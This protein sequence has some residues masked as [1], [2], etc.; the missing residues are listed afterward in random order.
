MNEMHPEGLLF[1]AMV[2]HRRGLFAW[3][4]RRFFDHVEL[5]AKTEARLVSLPSQGR[6]IYVMRTRSLLDYLFF[7]HLFL[8][9]GMPLARFANG[10]NLT[11]LRGSLLVGLWGWLNRDRRPQANALDLLE[12]VI[13]RGQS[14]LIFMKKRA[15]NT[16]RLGTRD[17]V[18][19]LV[20]L[21]RE[22]D[23]PLLLVPQ[24]IAW[25][26]NPPSRRRSWV[27]I[28]FGEQEASGRLRKIG[29]FI[30]HRR[31]ATVRVGAP[32]NLKEVIAAHEGWSDARLAR[33]VRRVLFIHLGHEAMSVRG[34]AVKP[35]PMIRREIL[36]RR[37]FI[38][39]MNEQAKVLG[40]TPSAVQEEAAAY[41]KEI[42]AS[43]RFDIL[44]I[45][46]RML[47]SLFT[48]VFQGVE[49]DVSEIERVKEA[50]K[51][52]RSAPLILAPCHKSHA[53]YLLLSWILMRHGFIAPH[54][55]AGIN[56]SFFP[57][58]PW[59][60]HSGAF[61]LRRSFKGLDLYKLVFRQ[62]L[63]KL[64]REG[65]PIEF[66]LE[67][68]RS[69]TG[70][71][72]QPKMGMLSMLLEG[73][74]E[75]E[76]KDLQFIPIHISY[77]RVVE[78][79]SYRHELTG[80]AKRSESVGGVVKAS[81]VL[82][83]R[84]GRIYVTLEAP[85]RLS[86]YAYGRGIDLT[87][88][89][90]DGFRSTTRA[91]AYHLMR[92]I[93]VATIITPSAL[94]GTVLLSHKRRGITGIR[95]RE[96]VGFLL[97]F[98][99]SRGARISRSIQHTLHLHEKYIQSSDERDIIEGFQARG[100]ALRPLI[101]EALLLLKRLV[102]IEE[103]G[104]QIIYIIPERNRIELDY[105]RNGVLS[106]LVS[107]AIVAT[108]IRSSS[109]II[110]RSLLREQCQNLS[111]WLRLEFIYET[112]TSFEDVFDSVLNRMV[113]ESL[114]VVNESGQIQTYDLITLDF[115][116]GALQHMIEGY[117]IATDALRFLAY[118]PMDQKIW[119]EKA[120]EHG[121]RE[122]LSGDLQRPEASSTA[123]LKAS[124]QR[125]IDEGWIITQTQP[126]ARKPIK[127]YALSPNIQ[128]DLII[129]KRD[130]LGAFLVSHR[131]E[132]PHPTMTLSITKRA[133]QSIN[134]DKKSK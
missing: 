18:G 44:Q 31:S 131:N 130:E 81:K 54:I 58:G 3:F 111:D 35:G 67:G 71:L 98:L 30:R 87:K 116:R 37:R 124:M 108:V 46:A 32:I 126:T 118:G 65:Y 43:W 23:T 134:L 100:E 36:E 26:P 62:Y 28:A 102:H 121:E 133:F 122:F 6:L 15:L 7:N 80:G 74:Q 112:N 99:M 14:A 38:N 88:I 5:D 49:V 95:L 17:F 42:A 10:V 115:L 73:L 117:W 72:L 19:R 53:D 76:F 101:D 85:V 8:K 9:L 106:M 69:R 61:F 91:L 34:P 2:D 119:V 107:D 77:E 50:A 24:L 33:K 79:G 60:R 103:R 90:E 123:I 66:F 128:L 110:S 64:V 97:S 86:E 41:L 75:G 29:H 93:Q 70:K 132:L 11:F 127:L 57:L 25:P 78:T 52:S 96:R 59:L 63:W 105:Y 129:E 40:K 45:F 83:Y 16:E 56:L 92:Q 104:G 48:K 84:Y 20:T 68:G 13:R 114:V 1:S 94:V 82:R 120:R 12:G 27:D 21:Q 22:M 47:D 4:A 89:D 51:L 109:G 39:A 125:S 113:I 55:A